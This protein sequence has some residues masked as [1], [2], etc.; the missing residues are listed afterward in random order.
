MPPLYDKAC[1]TNCSVVGADCMGLD[2][3]RHH[4]LCVCPNG[5]I[6]SHEHPTCG[7][8]KSI[9]FTLNSIVEKIIIFLY[10]AL[11]SHYPHT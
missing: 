9:V 5:A 8:S 2:P 3:Q 6:L 11:P 10:E 4:F 1:Q 7:A